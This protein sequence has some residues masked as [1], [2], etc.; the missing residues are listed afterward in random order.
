MKV[1]STG[2]VLWDIFRDLDG[3]IVE[4]LGGAPLNISCS[5]HR[6]GHS[7][8]FV[9][10]VGSDPRGEWTMQKMQNMGL[11]T[12]F[13]QRT[14]DLETGTALVT[15]DSHR[16]AT[17]VIP[18]PA[19]FD[20]L[21]IDEHLLSRLQ[22]L[23]ADWLYFGTLAQTDKSNLQLLE[24]LLKRLPQIRGFYDI[25]LREGHWNLPLVEHLSSLAAVIKLNDVEAKLLFELIFPNDIFS[26]DNFCRAWSARYRLE[27]LCVTL[28]DQ[29][30]AMYRD[31]VL[32]E[33]SGIPVQVADTVGAGDAFAAGLLHALLQPWPLEQQAAF[34]NGL[35]ALVASRQGATPD[36]TVAECE[37][38]IATS[39]SSAFSLN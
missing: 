37:Q 26:L 12:Q 3:S 16:H 34:A 8:A 23:E 10:G 19:A 30:C 22:E 25:N 5:L 11:S 21:R 27:V 4:I 36:W 24:A 33:F 38:L 6:L 15:L 14:A 13:V 20:Q 1:I 28:G 29:G 9:T 17:F 2:E 32:R 39:P 31:G 7:V 35:G 18:R